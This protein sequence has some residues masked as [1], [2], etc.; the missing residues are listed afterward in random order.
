MARTDPTTAIFPRVPAAAGHYES[1]YLRACHPSGRLG[2][3]IRYTVHKRPRGRPAGS[4]WFTLFDASAEG[5]VASKV[6]VPEPAAGGGAWI[7]VGDS[8]LGEGEA[9]G[10]APSEVCDAAWD[11]RFRSGE[12]PLHHLPA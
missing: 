4:L 1:F 11:L 7:R 3:W 8:R 5:P 10:M 12:G 6:T 2:V 9:V